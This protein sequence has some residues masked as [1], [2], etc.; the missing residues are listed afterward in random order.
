MAEFIVGNPPFIG[1]GGLMRGHLGD[2]Y[3]EALQKA[4]PRVPA[5]A[6]FVMQWWDRAAHTLLAENSPLIRFGFVTTNSITQEFNRRVIA[7]Y[8]APVIASEAK[9]STETGSPRGGSAR[10]DANARD[11]LSLV[12]AIPDHPWTKATKDGAA[13]RIAMTVAERGDHDGE[14]R[15]VTKEM[16]VD[17]DDPSIELARTKASINADLTAGADVTKA[18]PLKANAGLSCNGMMLAGQGFKVEQSQAKALAAEEGRD[19]STVLRG[20][21]GGSE[22]LNGWRK[23][24][25]ID[26]CGMAE[27]EA[28]EQYPILYQ[29]VLRTVKPERD[30]SRDKTFKEKWWLFGRVRPELRSFIADLNRYVATTETSK[31][32]IFQFVD[33]HVLPDHMVIAIG[34]NDAFHLGVLQSRMHLEWTL[35]TGGWLGFGNDNRYSKSKTFDP[36]P[37][38][39]ATPEQRE[40]IAELAEEL[41]ATRKAALA[42]TDKLTMTELYN[43]REKLRSG[44][45]MD[46]KEQR[47]A[48]KAR[49][50]IVNRLHE[51]L[52]QAVAD[53]YGWGEE[54]RAGTLGP[55][56]IVARLVALNHERAA[57]EKAG[58][59]RWLRPDYQEPR[60]GKK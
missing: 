44:A 38:P 26:F 56:E 29:H 48:T 9:Q 4:N 51:Q 6:D 52:D 19:T 49:A 55:S 35:R 1:K 23:Q 24:S 21:I 47:R 22:L 2:D 33:S 41:D 5:S 54:W 15:E 34:T 28:R 16:W 60:F 58:K 53:A 25:V 40:R 31:H 39:D 42:E 10:D 13:V 59:I 11:R 57:E 30:K 18:A 8:L 12:M 14:L 17:T 27:Q 46:E 43:L 45:P 20:Y 32:R 37:F 7:N 36:F 50:A 3:V